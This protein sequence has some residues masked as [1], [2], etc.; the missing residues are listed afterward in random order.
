MKLVVVYGPPASGKL[1]VATE[2]A[3]MTGFK[4]FHNHLTVNAARSVFEMGSRELQRVLH[5]LRIVVFEEAA[6]AG[7]SIV[8]TFANA[9]QREHERPTVVDR[10][11]DE[12]ERVVGERGGAVCRVQLRPPV[13]VLLERVG[14][15]SRTGHQKLDDPADLQVFLEEREVYDLIEPTDLS[16]DNSEL[17]PGEVAAQIRDHFAL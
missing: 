14:T 4:L 12:I 17:S 3:A 5:R 16:I 13:E 9:R 6:D 1:T 8:Y 15:A 11:T 7:I 10:F 2:L